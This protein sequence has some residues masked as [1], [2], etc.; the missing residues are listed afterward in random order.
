MSPTK[1]EELRFPLTPQ[2]EG[3]W[4]SSFHPWTRCLLPEAAQWKVGT[5]PSC[6]LATNELQDSGES[7]KL[8]RLS[9][10]ICRRSD[11]CHDNVRTSPALTPW[12]SG[13]YQP[14]FPLP[15]LQPLL[16]PCPRLQTSD[17]P[18][19]DSAPPNPS[20]GW[21]MCGGLITPF[22]Y[23]WYT[24]RVALLPLV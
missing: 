19:L 18:P 17:Y 16:F 7:A 3:S 20:Q 13:L 4:D 1:K 15:D 6:L 24:H 9:F 23:T 10:L 2:L 8:D 12:K 21:K 5:R 14:Y 22:P 11:S